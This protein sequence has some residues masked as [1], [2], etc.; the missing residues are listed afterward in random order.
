[1]SNAIEIAIDAEDSDAPR[2]GTSRMLL[3]S[4][5]LAVLLGGGGFFAV[6]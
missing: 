3:I 6:F 5:V 1:M 2:R 4:L